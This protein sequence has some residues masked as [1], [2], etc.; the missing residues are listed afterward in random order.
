MTTEPL[1][2]TGAG[3]T[4]GTVADVARHARP[5]TLAPVMRSI[6]FA[7]ALMAGCTSAAGP[8]AA[9]HVSLGNETS[10]SD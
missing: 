8:K 1:A 9:L 4:P 3:L 6:G 5:V 2:L 10:A 7:P